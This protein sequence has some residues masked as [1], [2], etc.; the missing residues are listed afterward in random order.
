V[1]GS[2]AAAQKWLLIE[3]ERAAVSAPGGS[4]S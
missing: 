3:H 2:G 4:G 1:F